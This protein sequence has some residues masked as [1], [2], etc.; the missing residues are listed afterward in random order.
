MVIGYGSWRLGGCWVR[1]WLGFRFDFESTWVL[2]MVAR[3]ESVVVN[4]MLA[5]FES[6]V[7]FASVWVLLRLGVGQDGVFQWWVLLWWWLLASC[8]GGGCWVLGSGC[9]C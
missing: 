3:F 5:G 1:C 8:F 2:S 4:W 7:G 9:G 6:M